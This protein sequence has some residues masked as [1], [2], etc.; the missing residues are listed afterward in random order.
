MP[1]RQATRSAHAAECRRPPAIGHARGGR[2]GVAAGFA[3]IPLTGPHVISATSRR[4]ICS[5][6]ISRSM[7][8]RLYAA[9]RGVRGSTAYPTLRSTF[10]QFYAQSIKSLDLFAKQVAVAVAA[11]ED[12]EHGFA[13]TIEELQR[14]RCPAH[15]WT[16]DKDDM[17]AIL[18]PDVSTDRAIAMQIKIAA[19]ESARWDRCLRT[20]AR[21]RACAR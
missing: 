4:P 17:F 11:D 10:E 20:P 6:R 18:G 13:S 19:A 12:L 9:S 14:P 16:Y 15:E 1:N 3:A 21:C 7:T 2:A 8:T 5:S